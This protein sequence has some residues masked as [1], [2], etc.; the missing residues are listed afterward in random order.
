MR[1]VSA[2]LALTGAL[3]L[4]SPLAVAGPYYA[5]TAT[6]TGANENPPNAS[7]GVGSALVTFDPTAHI[8]RVI[9]SFSGLTGTTT[10][11]HIHCCVIAPANGGVAT[12]TP[13]F[14]G[15]PAGVTAGSYNGAFDTTLAS[16]YRAGFIT[17]NGGTPLSAE[18]ALF[19]GLKAGQ[20]YL[21]IHTS[22]FGGG[23][24]RGFLTAPEPASLGLF[25]MALVALGLR[26]RKKSA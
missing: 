1:K 22:T 7:P 24:I 25:S 3:T 6:L 14:A 23:E 16:T 10:A 11:S 15:F 9:T 5:F 2:L 13:S 19:N 26:G 21:N 20:A 17:A 12:Q 18:A 8:L 4:L